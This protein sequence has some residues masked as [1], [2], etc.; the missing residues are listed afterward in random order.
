M[1]AMRF[2]FLQSAARRHP[3]RRPGARG[4][5]VERGQFEPANEDGRLSFLS[6][7]AGDSS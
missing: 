4:H 1:E 6:L 2:Y 5:R 3:V 7:D